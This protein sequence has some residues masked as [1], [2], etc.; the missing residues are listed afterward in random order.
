MKGNVVNKPTPD[1]EAKEPIG[2]K[3]IYRSS[4]PRWINSL[5]GTA[6][7]QGSTRERKEVATMTRPMYWY[8]RWQHFGD[9]M[10][11]ETA[12]QNPK[13][14]RDN[15]YMAMPLGIDWLDPSS[16]LNR[17]IS[18]ISTSTGIVS[19][20][21]LLTRSAS[22]GIGSV[23]SVSTGIYRSQTIGRG[24]EPMPSAR[25]SSGTICRRRTHCA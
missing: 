21:S 25:S 14:G 13:I 12:F 5:Q 24:S 7:H 23:G 11:I 3:W 15:I 19:T 8:L 17:I 9:H 10:D 16:T 1:T 18:T 4:Q 2:C 22:T 6:N 20:G